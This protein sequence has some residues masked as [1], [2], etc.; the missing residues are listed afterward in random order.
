MGLQGVFDGVLKYIS[1]D[2]IGIR[3][4]AHIFI[5]SDNVL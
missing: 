5:L 4:T 1:E 3:T 2:D